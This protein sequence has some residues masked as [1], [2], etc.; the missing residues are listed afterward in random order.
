MA[1]CLAKAE[2]VDDSSGS[3]GMF[4]V[5][6]FCG[7]ASVA[8]GGGLRSRADDRQKPGPRR[9]EA[10]PLLNHRREARGSRHALPLRVYETLTCPFISE[11]E[12]V[13][14]SRRSCRPLPQRTRHGPLDRV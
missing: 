2:E 8:G 10:Q 9:T 11:Q 7:W 4:A 6:L 5:G 12:H 1:G 13:A 3:L 14:P